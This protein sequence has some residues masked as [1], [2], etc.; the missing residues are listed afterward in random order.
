MTGRVVAAA[1][2]AI[3]WLSFDSPGRRNAVSLAMWEAIPGLVGELE[4]DP[5]IR[6][7]ALRGAGEEGFASGADISEFDTVRHGPGAAARYEEA[8]LRAANALG[9]SRL[10]VVA[11]IRGGCVGGGLAIAL[12]ADLRLAGEDAVFSIPAARLGLGLAPEA[13][14]RLV[15]TVGEPRAKEILFTAGRFDAR[16]A[17]AIGLVH[18]VVPPADLESAVRELC[19]TLAANAPLTIRAAKSFLGG[20]RDPGLVRACFESEDWAEGRSAFAQKRRPEFR[21]R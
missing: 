20:S 3:G 7:L 21:G 11:M 10:P 19:G 2:G 6:V 8:F 1:D 9:D 5:R 17:E 12:W 18:R 14:D 15:G 4:A 13:C 16:R